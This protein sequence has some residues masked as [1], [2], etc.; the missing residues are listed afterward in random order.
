MTTPRGGQRGGEGGPFEVATE[1]D[2][3]SALAISMAS[4]TA[5]R[6]ARVLMARGSM[7]EP[8]HSCPDNL[9]RSCCLIEEGAEQKIEQQEV[10]LDVKFCCRL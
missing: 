2:T 9:S 10:A 7:W 8:E 1:R 4:F 5:S 6:G 3:L